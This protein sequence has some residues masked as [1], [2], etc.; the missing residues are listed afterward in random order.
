[1]FGQPVAISSHA[2]YRSGQRWRVFAAMQHRDLVFRR[3][4]LDDARADESGS[5]D[6][7]DAHSHILPDVEKDSVARYYNTAIFEA[8]HFL[9]VGRRS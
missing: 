1:M 7:Q 5:A 9:Y 4:P 6:H 8:D 2:P 3:Q